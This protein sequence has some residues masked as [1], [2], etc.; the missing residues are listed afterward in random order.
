MFT[1]EAN[2]DTVREI[3]ISLNAIVAVTCFLQICMLHHGLRK[4][5]ISSNDGADIKSM[6]T[7]YYW[8]L[9]CPLFVSTV[10]DLAADIPRF[11]AWI[12]FVVQIVVAMYFKMFLGLMVVSSG[13]W[14]RLR[15]ILTSQSDATKCWWFFLRC[16]NAWRGLLQRYWMCQLIF[17]K[18]LGSF[19]TAAYHELRHDDS[20]STLVFVLNMVECVCTVIPMVGIAM[21]SYTLRKKGMIALKHTIAKVA[22]IR[23]LTPITQFAQTILEVSVGRGKIKG[24]TDFSPMQLAHRMLSF[25]LSVSM[26]VV[27]LMTFWAYPTSD[28]D[29]VS[30]EKLR[31]MSLQR[32]PAREDGY[33]K[34]VDSD[35]AVFGMLEERKNTMNTITLD[36]D[37]IS[38]IS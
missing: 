14:R 31:S 10:A 16:R 25:V 13:G 8:I 23:V 3:E 5:G 20:Q 27:S 17:F 21:F 33:I 12:Y 2:E 30:E 6:I 35:P 37:E 22:V 29:D 4:R 26:L 24:S 28:F 9:M 15:A 1:D 32:I 11:G 19:T 7:L 34:F 38:M 36:Q 18:P